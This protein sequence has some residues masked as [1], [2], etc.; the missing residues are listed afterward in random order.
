[1]SIHDTILHWTDIESSDDLTMR[2]L[3]NLASKPPEFAY[4]EIVVGSMGTFKQFEHR[5]AIRTEK[6]KYIN[7]SLGEGL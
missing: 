1:M 2:S 3:T 4:S 5:R 7:S 6:H